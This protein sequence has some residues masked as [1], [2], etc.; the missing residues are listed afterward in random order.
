MA[1]TLLDKTVLENFRR[2]CTRDLG[3]RISETWEMEEAEGC[4]LLT[5]FYAYYHYFQANYREAA[6]LREGAQFYGNHDY[7]SICGIFPAKD[8]DE[9]LIDILIAQ[10]RTSTIK[11][12]QLRE[13][14]FQRYKGCAEFLWSLRGRTSTRGAIE[15]RLRD[16]GF[17]RP[18]EAHPITIRFLLHV[19]PT[20]TQ[21]ETISKWLDTRI[22]HEGALLRP[23]RLDLRFADDIDYEVSNTSNAFQF[24]PHWDLTLDRP[25]NACR[26]L[27]GRCE[28]M[29]VNVKAT[30]LQALWRDY[31]YRGLLSQNLR[32]YVS[33]PRVDDAMFNTIAHA[34]TDFWYF[35]NG[36]TIV[37]KSFKRNGA[38]LTLE[39]FSVVNGGQTIHNIGTVSDLPK[40][41]SIP[42]KI[43]AMQSTEGE[44][45][46]ED[47][48]IDLIADICTATN[49]QKPIKASDAVANRKE[50]RELRRALKAN[51]K[52]SICLLTKKGEKLNRRAFPAPWQSAKVQQYGQLLLSFLYQAPCTARNQT[53]ELFENEAIY[54]QLFSGGALPP[55]FVKD[56]LRLQL[57]IRAYR[58]LWKTVRGS[59]RDAN[60]N[61]WQRYYLV[62]NG[63]YLLLA[64]VGALCKVYANETLAD[65]LRTEPEEAC[66]KQLCL[67]DVCYPFLLDT[68]DELDCSEGAPIVR[69]LDFCLEAFIHV[70]YVTYCADSSKSGDYSNFAKSDI[71]Y[72]EYVQRAFIRA[73][74]QGF[75]SKE[76]AILDA[77]LRC[78]TPTEREM[79]AMLKE[80]HPLR[81]GAEQAEFDKEL[82][83]KLLANFKSFPAS[84]RRGAPL[85]GR[86]V[87]RKIIAMK[88]QTLHDLEGSKLSHAQITVYGQYL[89]EALEDAEA[90]REGMPL[91][92]SEPNDDPD[93]DEA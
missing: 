81:W 70:G 80:H 14:I 30:S 89:L 27:E 25:E 32:Y 15:Q 68:V 79:C 86:K 34:P 48:R 4:R 3:C 21:R 73:V 72:I 19:K 40:D 8:E 36:L 83:E 24:V 52:C 23:F 22:E 46:P 74:K 66:P 13:E 49:S 43:V 60:A 29:F 78:P 58:K 38:K 82:A 39:D 9:G 31:S 44:A 76:R 92:V 91:T 63:E 42:C 69:L 47:E 93:E 20:N 90:R 33:L 62:A 67:C 50:I 45:L 56:L 2:E 5:F 1:M 7:A 26:Y 55:L 54:Q 18:D 65:K 71:R 77:T 75:S 51:P 12:T 35:N 16:L 10:E 87:L 57:A 61:Q 17:V 53:K 84:K 41:F 64:C 11:P 85:P 59:G 37:C 6:S 28:A 88:P